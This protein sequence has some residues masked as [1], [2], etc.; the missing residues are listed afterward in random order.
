MAYRYGSTLLICGKFDRGARKRLKSPSAGT[1]IKVAEFI[2][3]FYLEMSFADLK[4]KPTFRPAYRS[5]P[6]H[7]PQMC[8]AHVQILIKALSQQKTTVLEHDAGVSH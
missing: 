7:L 6:R 5:V 2:Y 1:Y 3:L 8:F 4:F